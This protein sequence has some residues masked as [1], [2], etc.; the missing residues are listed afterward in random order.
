V[1]IEELHERY[2]A[3]ARRE[4]LFSFVQVTLLGIVAG[5]TVGYLASGD[6]FTLK[7]AGTAA[8]VASLVWGLGPARWAARRRTEAHAAWMAAEHARWEAEYARLNDGGPG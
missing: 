7:A 1:L 3:A 8:A 6:S 4:Y 2:L 5:L